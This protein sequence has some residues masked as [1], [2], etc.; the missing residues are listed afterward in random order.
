MGIIIGHVHN[1]VLGVVLNIVAEVLCRRDVSC[2]PKVETVRVLMHP[3]HTTHSSHVATGDR[4]LYG[5]LV[6]QQNLDGESS[7]L[8][9]LATPHPH[10]NGWSRVYSE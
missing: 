1:F 8:Q 4:F 6:S 9:S 10:S 3:D 2:T 7:I 5:V